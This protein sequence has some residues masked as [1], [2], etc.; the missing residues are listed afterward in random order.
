MSIVL[1]LR[2]ALASCE[3]KLKP[4]P[5]SLGALEERVA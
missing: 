4:Q 5:L 1:G 3:P 2:T